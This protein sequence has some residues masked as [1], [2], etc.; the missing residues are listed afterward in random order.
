MAKLFTVLRIFMCH[1]LHT[2]KIK[3][4]L[5]STHHYTNACK[6]LVFI[7]CFCW[8]KFCLFAFFFSSIL[9][10]SIFE[11]LCHSIHSLAHFTSL[12]LYVFV[13]MFVTECV[14]ISAKAFSISTWS[15]IRIR[16]AKAAPASVQALGNFCIE[17][18]V[19]VLASAVQ[20]KDSIHSFIRSRASWSGVCVCVYLV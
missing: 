3:Q 5:N 9:F 18:L 4:T 14:S 7:C 10:Y 16:K 11:I 2:S 13:L 12:N 8:F 20:T 15:S 1:V 17:M 6:T 19:V